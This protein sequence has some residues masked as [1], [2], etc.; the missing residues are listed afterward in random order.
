MVYFIKHYSHIY[1][2]AIFFLFGYTFNDS[3]FQ[4][5]RNIKGHDTELDM[6]IEYTLKKEKNNKTFL[7][8]SVSE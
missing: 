8:L 5:V 1:L 4:T 7:P 2:H 3:N 6:K